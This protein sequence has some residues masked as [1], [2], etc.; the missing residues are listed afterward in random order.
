M[1]HGC[2]R[3]RST[4]GGD[5]TGEAPL[6]EGLI[7]PLSDR[8][9]YILEGV[10][11]GFSNEQIARRAEISPNTVASHVRKIMTR[12]NCTSRA[13][14]VAHGY[15]RGL[16]EPSRWPPVRRGIGSRSPSTA[17]PECQVREEGGDRS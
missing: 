9:L 12:F 15:V 8:Q 2:E 14:M 17:R 7:K 10:A 6:G 16:L 5:G 3:H 1:D 13:T 4:D 11:S